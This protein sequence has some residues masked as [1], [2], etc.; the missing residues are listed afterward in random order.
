MRMMDCLNAAA[1]PTH[2]A[3]VRRMNLMR[4]MHQR[5]AFAL[6]CNELRGECMP[7]VAMVF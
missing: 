5:M 4:R 2:K 7:N 6:T 1:D 3:T